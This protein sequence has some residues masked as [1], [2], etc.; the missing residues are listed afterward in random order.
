M[1]VRLLI[2]LLVLSEE[3]YSF[4]VFGTSSLPFFLFLCLSAQSCRSLVQASLPSVRCWRLC[5]RNVVK[6]VW[7]TEWLLF[8]VLETSFTAARRTVSVTWPRF[9]SLWSRRFKHIILFI[10]YYSTPLLCCSLCFPNSQQSCPQ[11][12][13]V[14][15]RSLEDDDDD[16]DMKEKELQTEALLCAFEIL[17]KSWPR[18]PQTQGIWHLLLRTMDHC[19]N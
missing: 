17:G 3:Q 6:R 8:A 15:P 12:G 1:Q 9:F 13:G 11:S 2:E 14:S 7:C 16:R 18:N 10:C 4:Y 5:W 19:S